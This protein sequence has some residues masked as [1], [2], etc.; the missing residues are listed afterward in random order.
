MNVSL[1]IIE[2]LIKTNNT[3]N[4]TVNELYDMCENEKDETYLRDA[5]LFD[6]IAVK[7]EVKEISNEAIKLQKEIE[8]YEAQLIQKESDLLVVSKKTY[9]K[10]KGHVN[11]GDGSKCSFDH[12]NRMRIRKEAIRIQ[13]DIKDLKGYIKENKALLNRINK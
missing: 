3:A 11:F 4:Y 12:I 8:K 1:S 6:N 9:K 10:S 13:S 2:G 7:E 5:I